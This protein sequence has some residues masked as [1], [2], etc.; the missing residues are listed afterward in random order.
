MSFAAPEM[1]I[2]HMTEIN[3]QDCKKCKRHVS[4]ATAVCWE[5]GLCSS[6]FNKSD[7]VFSTIS[8]TPLETKVG[9]S[10]KNPFSMYLDRYTASEIKNLEEKK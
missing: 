4:R 8:N 10:I 3:P 2:S 6:C 1:I 5:Y 9:P 7:I